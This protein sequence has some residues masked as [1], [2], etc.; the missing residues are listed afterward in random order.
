MFE[1]FTLERIDVGAAELR[2][3]HGGTGPPVLL[4]H[5][6][7]RTHATWHKV[8]PVLAERFTVVCPDLR[9]YGQSS[10]PPTT[11]DHAPYSKRA[12]A[13]DCLALMEALGH[14]RFCAAGHD[15]GSYVA[16]RLAVDHPGAVR[17]LCLMEGI[18]IGEALA[19]CDATFAARWFHWFFFGQTD[20]PAEQFINANPDA[21][22]TA[23][24]AQMGEEAYADYRQA[25]HDP[26]TVHAMIEDYRAGLGIDREHDEADRAAGR[27]VT[28]PLLFVWAARDDLED[29]YGDPLA[30]WRDWADDV[31]GWPI[32]CGH[33]IAEESPDELA[34][35]LTAFFAEA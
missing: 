10:K 30:I 18:P 11:Q 7:P 16:R 32:D 21:W 26:Q 2:V 4:V 9:G 15:R 22:Y 24:A 13:A 5:G 35:S 20:K 23:T 31:R 6:H 33:H 12:M 8:A 14:P 17:R 3:R 1:G 27:R 34:A 29:L 25:I 19:R 28:C